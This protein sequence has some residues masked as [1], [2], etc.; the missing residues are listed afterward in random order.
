M[1]RKF[2]LS[3]LA[4]AA[5]ASLS[6]CDKDP[7]TGDIEIV[8]KAHYD[9]APLV[10]LGKYEY[11]DTLDILFQRFN[12][13]ISNVALLKEG[14]AARTELIDIDFVNFDEV[15]NLADAE[16]GYSILVQK[17]P[18]G[19]YRSID[20]GLGVPED[21]NKTQASNYPPSHPLGKD[22]HYWSAWQSYIFTMIN[23]KVDA[24][25]D[26]LFDDSSV[27]Y[28]LGSDAVYRTK[29]I[30]Y[31]LQVEGGK[32]TRIVLEINLHEVFRDG[33]TYMDIIANPATHDISNLTVAIKA[34]ENLQQALKAAQ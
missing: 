31:P 6:S 21:L 19:N 16:A 1:L 11:N 5:L 17:V 18:A 4:I 30:D 22:S 9:G 25:G 26:G 33:A 34:Q 24:N 12:F 32:T 13:Y 10:M 2:I 27:L 8:F 15:D 3:V 7:K 28:H 20:L 23:A 14:N 29:T